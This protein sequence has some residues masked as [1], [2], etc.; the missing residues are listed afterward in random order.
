M[1]L[2]ADLEEAIRKLSVTLEHIQVT[3]GFQ[4]VLT[5]AQLEEVYSCA[6]ILAACVTDYLAKAIAYL[7][8]GIGIL[9]ISVI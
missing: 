9:H 1:N 2:A 4:E 8:A 6:L 5:E 3:E 7:D